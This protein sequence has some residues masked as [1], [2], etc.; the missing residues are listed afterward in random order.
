MEQGLQAQLLAQDFQ[1]SKAQLE[2]YSWKRRAAIL[3]L[4]LDSQQEDALHLQQF[5]RVLATE[6]RHQQQAANTR[7]SQHIAV[8]VSCGINHAYMAEYVE[9]LLDRHMEM[10]E[11]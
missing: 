2:T 6:L 7:E 4:K 8:H 11:H 9:K 1:L 3:Q 10:I 5:Q